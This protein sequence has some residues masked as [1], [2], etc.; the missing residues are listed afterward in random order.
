MSERQPQYNQTNLAQMPIPVTIKQ[1]KH[2]SNHGGSPAIKDFAIT[3]VTIVAMVVGKNDNGNAV[4]LD[5]EDSTGI[6]QGLE[7]YNPDQTNHLQEFVYVEIFMKVTATNDG[8]KFIIQQLRVVDDFSQVVSHQLQAYAHHLRNIAPTTPQMSLKVHHAQ[9]QAALQQNVGTSG[10]Q[11]QFTGINYTQQGNNNQ[12]NINHNMN[13][14]STSSNPRDVI[15]KYLQA[16]Q[17][18]DGSTA[19]E[20]ARATGLALNVVKEQ[21]E[22][23]LEEGQI[24]SAID[25]QHFSAV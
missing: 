18:D 16:N 8:F 1:L 3:M 7:C 22:T 12:G 6:L 14:Y 24:F 21:C 23:L 11:A 2:A 9:Q 15:V 20:I 10:Y 17:V 19:Q 25:D 4:T 5:V 13:Q